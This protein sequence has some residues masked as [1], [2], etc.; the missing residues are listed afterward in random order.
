MRIRNALTVVTAAVVLVGVAAA[1]ASA[2]TGAST[3]CSDG[4]GGTEYPVLTTG[5]TLA[6]ERNGSRLYICYSTAEPGTPGDVTGGLI[7]V[8]L[9]PYVGNPTGAAVLLRCVEDFNTG[10]ASVCATWAT[11]LGYPDDVA[12]TIVPNAAC[13]VT[14]NSVC[15]VWVPGLKIN[16][17]AT[18]DPLLWADVWG[19]VITVGVPGQCVSVL[20]PCP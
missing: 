16:T 4:A 15:Q 14:V 8:D 17:D 10:V 5:G 6:A 19:N 13:A 3:I 1:P 11:V 9:D 2:G 7:M 18:P 20:V 12:P